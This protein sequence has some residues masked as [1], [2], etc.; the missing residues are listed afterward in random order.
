MPE[1]KEDEWDKILNNISIISFLEGLSIGGKVYH[2]YSIIP[3]NNN[4]EVVTENSIYIASNDGTT[5]P[6]YHNVLEKGLNAKINNSYIGIFNM[7]LNRKTKDLGF[8]IKYYFPKLYYADY[9]S[10]VF[11]TNVETLKDGNIYKYLDKNKALATIYYK[12]LARERY[13]MYRVNNN[14][15][16]W[17]KNFYKN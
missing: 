2:G 10:I 16:E 11:R 14:V 3:N 5:T 15:D 1:L 12:A 6:T 7:D 13:G 9:N 8:T 4:E 17:K